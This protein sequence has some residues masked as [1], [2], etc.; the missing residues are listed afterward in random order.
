MTDPIRVLVC[1][2]HPMVREGL[3]AVLDDAP[4]FEVVAEAATGE[5]AVA[6][7][8][9]LAPDVVVMDLHLEGQNGIEATRA[10]NVESSSTAVLVL[11]MHADDDAV[12]AAL[13]AG[14]RGY[15]LK[16]AGQTEILRAIEAVHNGQAIFG[17]AVAGA[18]LGL[19]SS[20]ADVALPFPELTDRERD[21][22]ALIADGLDNAT[23]GRRLVISPKTVANHVSNIFAK[24][25]LRTRAE[26]VA[27]ARDAGIGTARR[28]SLGSTS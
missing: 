22:L 12:R 23:I 15:L 17:S 9:T 6:L 18:V 3:R 26:A 8:A 21:I 25:H 24:L 28:R 5:D 16:G 1:D 13:R 4:G 19:A 20:T 11:T 10:I 2:D 14:A 27:V 7:V